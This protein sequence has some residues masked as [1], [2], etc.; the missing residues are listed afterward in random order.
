MEAALRQLV[1]AI[2]S[3]LSFDIHPYQGKD[4]L[5]ERLPRVLK[6]YAAWLP[7]NSR[8]VVVVDRDDDDCVALKRSIDAMAR[9]A[10]LAPKVRGG[11][12]F[13]V[14]TRIAVEELEAWLLGDIAALVAAYPGVPQT[15]GS[16]RRFRHVDEIAGGTWEALEQVLQQAGYFAEGMPKIHVARE[17]A[18]R[19]EPARNR[20]P[21]FR[22]FRDG[23]M[24]L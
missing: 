3:D 12:R 14:M 18:M 6:G 7:A 16:K 11:S 8:V 20:S 24:A 17:V 15:L 5:L 1:P 23:L 10:G 22:T 13:Q 9:R 21:S 19:M 2:R 4:D